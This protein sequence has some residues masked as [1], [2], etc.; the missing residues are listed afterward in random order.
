M[1]KKLSYISLFSGAGIGCYGFKGQGFKCLASN[2]LLE[3]RIQFQIFNEIADEP[4]RYISGDISNKQ[5]KNKLIEYAGNNLDVLIATPPCQG[6]SV[7]NHKKNNELKRNSLVVESIALTQKIN[8]KYFIFENV[9]S[10]LKTMCTD[11]DGNLVTIDESIDKNLSKIYNIYSK[12]INLSEYG[13]QSSRTRTLVIGVRKDLNYVSPLDIFPNYKNPKKLKNLIGDLKN[14]NRMGDIDSND[15]YHHFREYDKRMRPWIQNLKEGESAFENKDENKIP[16][17]I[18][19]GNVVFNKSS[20]GDKYRRNIWDKVGPCI[21]TRND[22]LASQNTI[23]PKDDRVFS[24]REIMK[25]MTVPKSFKW[26]KEPN[27]F[28]NKL[29]PKDKK[30]FLKKNELNIRHCLGEGVPT[31]VFTSIAKNII[32]CEEAK[33]KKDLLKIIYENNLQD[34]QNLKRYIKNRNYNFATSRIVELSN[35]SRTENRAYYTSP[36]ICFSLVQ[37]LPKYK[38]NAEINILEPSV[39]SGS[40]LPHI[41]E[42]YRNCERVNLDLIDIDENSIDILKV[43]ISKIKV[44][45]NFKLRFLVKDFLDHDIDRLYDV[46]IGNPPFGKIS[47]EYLK[48]I[49]IHDPKKNRK[50]F[51]V[52]F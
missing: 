41:F 38:N 3:K 18:I 35:S 26:S 29:S 8:P 51:L 15:I 34:H 52:F 9:R 14:F 11:I 32:R 44:P 50:I 40:F 31:E 5:N 42:H 43:L 6:M 1:S 21:H 17:Q 48:S 19:N 33:N 13:S 12:V 24:I 46:I 30:L 45:S 4:K 16:H 10:F 39:G 28:L 37:S 25:M 36:S 27:D 2:E 20:N 47:K 49:N 23:H 7:A 22:I